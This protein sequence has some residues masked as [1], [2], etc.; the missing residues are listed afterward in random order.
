M[1]IGFAILLNLALVSTFLWPNALGTTFPTVVW[2][3]LVLVW[4]ASCWVTFRS[5]PD[6]MAVGSQAR[7][8]SDDLSHTLFNQAQREYLRGNW[9]EAETLL[10]KRLENQPRDIES[11]LLLATL[12]RH[13]RRLHAAELELN[14][15]QKFDEAVN[16]EFEI[17][18]ERQ[19]IDLIEEAEREDNIDEASFESPATV[20][21]TEA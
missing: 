11:R 2:P 20:G 19:L 14:T 7:E 8:N 3:T 13:S 15:I 1:A 10:Q 4:I 12:L 9:P 21:L 6:V 5:L 17:R 16:W 18:R